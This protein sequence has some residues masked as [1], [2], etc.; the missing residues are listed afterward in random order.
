MNKKRKKHKI[1]YLSR[2]LSLPLSISLPREGHVSSQQEEGICKPWKGSLPRTK[3]ASTLTLNTSASTLVRKWHPLFRFLVW[4]TWYSS[5]WAKT[6]TLPFPNQP[7]CQDSQPYSASLLLL[8]MNLRLI[9]PLCTRPQPPHSS[10][11]CG[12]WGTSLHSHHLWLHRAKHLERVFHIHCLT[13]PSLV[14]SLTLSNQAFILRI[15]MKSLP[16]LSVISTSHRNSTN[17]CGRN[18]WMSPQ[19]VRTSQ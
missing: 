14:L 12:A 5:P 3:S 10:S 2:S 9:P 17:T 15:L 13:I 18:G 4:G 1:V 7:T 11:V 6:H 16:R 8:E 19:I